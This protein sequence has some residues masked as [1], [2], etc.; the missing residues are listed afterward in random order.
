MD[1]EENL[2]HFV[3]LVGMLVLKLFEST[4]QVDPLHRML[5]NVSTP[6]DNCLGELFSSFGCL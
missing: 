5:M 6:V 4:L 1:P 3:A 2:F